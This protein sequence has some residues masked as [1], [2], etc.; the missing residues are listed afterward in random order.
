VIWRESLEGYFEDVVRLAI[1]L[2]TQTNTWMLQAVHICAVKAGYMF[3]SICVVPLAG[4][5]EGYFLTEESY[6]AE[7]G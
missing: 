4:L 2:V 5:F 6:V 7:E 3:D 1:V